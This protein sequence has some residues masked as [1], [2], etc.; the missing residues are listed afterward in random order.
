[1]KN[2][3]FRSA[4][5]RRGGVGVQFSPERPVDNSRWQAPSVH[6]VTADL[7]ISLQLSDG[8]ASLRRRARSR[9]V[10]RRHRRQRNQGRVLPSPT[11]QAVFAY[12]SEK[13]ECPGCVL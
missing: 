7:R 1:M 9:G 2:P 12:S 8:N 13:V 3:S 6:R 5:G 10:P 11:R 4:L